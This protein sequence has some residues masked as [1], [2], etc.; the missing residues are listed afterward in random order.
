MAKI[1]GV[2]NLVLDTILTLDHYPKEDDEVR[3][4]SR[5]FRF[6]G[7]TA[8]TLYVLSQLGHESAIASTLATDEQAKHLKKAIQDQGISTE[9]IQRFIKG[10]TPT[11]YIFVSKHTGSR[12]ITHYRDLPELGF[13]HFAKI[14]VEAYDWLHFEGRNMD[15]LP[16]MLNIAKTFLDRQPI[17]LEI[18]KAR[19][20]IEALFSSA[21]LLLFSHH[22]AKQKGYQDA[23]SLLKEAH[24]AAPQ[25]NLVCTWGDRGAW[26]LSASGELH[27]EPAQPIKQLVDT[28]GA[29]DTFN[30]AIIHHLLA[31]ANLK[32]AVHQASL[33]A[34]RKCQQFGLD[35][36]LQP[37]ASRKPIANIKHISSSK[38][39]VV[40]AP[41]RSHKVVL[42]KYDD[43]IKAYENNCP[44]QDVPLD[45]AYKI[46]INPFEM[47]MK[48]SVHD[49]YFRIDD[50]VCIEGPC[51]RDELKPVDIEIDSDTGGIYLAE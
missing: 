5:Q 17:S 26:C 20:G 40:P 31:G 10:A 49:A 36:L 27:H 47:T 42:I 6:G 38:A 39:T 41:G 21:N 35:N 15:A 32:Q 29:G 44:H 33:L 8:N 50:G 22:Y 34:A 16:G 13:E 1:L 12:S 9:H 11:S 45:E 28:L 48:C 51:W 37:L 2:G 3:A 4:Q 7:N 25:A 19:D 24:K 30:A 14:E 43:Q 23:E 18:E 46:D